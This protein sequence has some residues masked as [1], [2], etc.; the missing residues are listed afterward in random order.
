MEGS[1]IVVSNNPES[2]SRE[3]LLLGTDP[4]TPI[5]AGTV[6]RAL[7]TG[8]LDGA[9]PSGSM[10]EFAF[11]MHHLLAA[12]S[13]SD[14]QVDRIFLLIEP[15]GSSATF[16]AYGSAISQRDVLGDTATTLDPG[17]SPSYSVSL[18]SLTGSLPSWINALSDNFGSRFINVSGRTI[19]Q[20]FPLF[21][22]RGTRGAS[23]DARIK[24][25]AT[26]GC[27]R[28][29][30]VAASA[31]NF[32]ESLANTLSKRQYAWGNVPSTFNPDGSQNVFGGAPCTDLNSIGWGRPAGIYRFE[33]WAGST[34]ASITSATSSRGWQFLSAP[35]NQQVGSSCVMNPQTPTPSSASQRAPALRYYSANNS[36]QSEGRDSDPWSTANYGAEYLLNFAATNRSGVCVTARLQIAAY[37]GQQ[38]CSGAVAK[39]RHYDGAFRIRENGVQ[40]PIARAF[41]RCPAGPTASTIAS[42]VLRPNETVDWNVQGFIPGLISAPAGVILDSTPAAA[43]SPGC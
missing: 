18:A 43:A 3:G 36:G 30:V 28:V 35:P 2:V 11:Y 22:L 19:S 23:L 31:N 32:S 10:R 34:S 39:S 5:V 38:A 37:P 12:P 27:L 25:R 4:M 1:P 42:K 17:K 15:A 40:K 26:S 20:P 8:T 29:R 7:T 41:V 6:N 16:N 24:I 9:C 14:Q 13:G 21:M 33:R